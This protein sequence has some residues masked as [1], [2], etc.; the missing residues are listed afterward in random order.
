MDDETGRPVTYTWSNLT[1]APDFPSVASVAA[2]LFPQSGGRPVDGVILMDPFVLQ[3]L[4]QYTGPID[5]EGLERNLNA[6]NA[7]DI[8]LKD[9]TSSPTTPSASTC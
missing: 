6:D 7:A 5:V 1:M 4:L 9:H 3:T 8:L 2:E